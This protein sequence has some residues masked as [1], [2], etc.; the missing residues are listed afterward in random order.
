[1]NRLQHMKQNME[2]Y[3]K[4]AKHYAEFLGNFFVKRYAIIST[5]A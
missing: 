3:P 5:K 1:M 2:T 4:L